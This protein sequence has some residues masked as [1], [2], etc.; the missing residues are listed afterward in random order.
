[1]SMNGM[2]HLSFG[3]GGL[4]LPAR[5]SYERELLVEHVIARARR[6]G[7]VRVAF[8]G[9]AWYV[10]QTPETVTARCGRCRRT[11]QPTWY[12]TAS[13]GVAY[14]LRCAF[15]SPARTGTGA[16]PTPEMRNGV[17]LGCTAA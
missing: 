17:P 15:G 7:A 8:Q 4:L 11:L 10:R 9:R 16:T 14:C 6:T 5:E 12:A 2:A 3:G 1:M 13:A